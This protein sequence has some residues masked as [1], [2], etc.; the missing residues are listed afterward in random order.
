MPKIF[1]NGRPRAKS[2]LINT[3]AY[4]ALCFNGEAHCC[5]SHCGHQMTMLSWEVLERCRLAGES[6][7]ME[8]CL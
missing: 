3:A 5:G 7:L 4:T 2:I 6:H 1:Y 8:A